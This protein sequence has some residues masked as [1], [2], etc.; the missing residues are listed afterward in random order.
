MRKKL[1]IVGAGDVGGFIANNPDLFL[2]KFEVVGIL[3]DDES[4]WGKSI[5]GC[6]ISGPIAGINSYKDDELQIVIGVAD[7]KIKQSIIDKLRKFNLQ[8]PSL[9]AK[10]AWISNGVKLGKGTI[11]YPGVSINHGSI[12]DDF[13]LLNMNCAIGHDT[14]IGSYSF[15]SPGVCTG[16]FTEL[17][18]GVIMG[19]N[20]STNQQVMVGDHAVIGGQAMLFNNVKE[21][22]TVVGVPAK[23]LE[24]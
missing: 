5:N 11:I 7:P 16:G 1:I 19:I 3:D 4:K 20:S 9:V 17:G 6:K 10:N 21:Y 24:K 8:Y 18:S 12:I 2:Q 23:L 15:L 13:A 14:T 22:S